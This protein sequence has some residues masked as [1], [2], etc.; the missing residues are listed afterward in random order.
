MRATGATRRDMILGFARIAGAGG[1]MAAMQALGLV[2]D[3]GTYY[4]PPA[5]P[6][7]AGKG[8]S[9]VVLGAGISGLVSAWELRKAGFNVTVLEARKRP[10]GRVWT[11]RGGDTMTHD[12][13]P[14]QRA[15]FGDGH[16]FNA[17]AARIPASH[18]G[19]HAYCR[20]LGVPL[21]VQVNVNEEA[22]FVSSKVRNG[23]PL[24]G[25]QVR[26]DVKGG[27]SELLAKAI[28]KGA[29]DDELTPQDRER[30]LDF[31]SQYGAL[32][33]RYEY[34]GSERLG[35]IVPPTVHGAAT[36]RVAPIP[37]SELIQ[38]PG[39]GFQISFG[40]QLYQ[41]STMMQPVGGIDA[42]P[43]AFAGRLKSEIRY[44]AQ[45]THLKRTDKGVRVLYSQKDGLSGT[46]E[47]DYAICAL[48]FSVLK[49]VACDF[50]A[51][52]QDMVNA[53]EYEA[54]CKVAW[55][56]PRFWEEGERIYGGISYSDSRCGLAWYPSYGFDMPEG[57][58]VGAYNFRGAAE[59][60]S[61]QSLKAQFEESRASLERVHPGKAHLLARPVA[62]NWA[63]VPHS[64]GAWAS[65]DPGTNYHTP[66]MR[67][68]LAGDGPIQFA[69]QHLSP[70]GA[71]MEAAIRSAHHALE[72]IY[73]QA[74][75]A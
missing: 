62:V 68:V 2:A 7:S 70:I 46:I 56:S 72:G 63:H 38:D 13:L 33:D 24:P 39:W 49:S 18:F 42:I 40:D 44:G 31:L 20:E 28:N 66:E 10:G 22:K 67:A 19:V 71:W 30:L 51:P 52:V 45:V 74:K 69:G 35:Y 29:L 11:V 53:M 27:I 60:F 32:G 54:S 8:K 47:A 3:A 26:N 61:A 73:A 16:Y 43:Y 57:I 48:P 12:H 6:G 37:L 50:S 59:P 65:E 23:L 21:E 64:M 41:Q 5:K 58:L 4:G 36:E 14:V 9:V 75:A 55:Q 1:A 34:T 17:G 15:A 25:R